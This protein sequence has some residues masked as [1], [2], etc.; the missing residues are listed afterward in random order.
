[1]IR[2]DCADDE[3]PVYAPKHISFDRCAYSTGSCQFD[4]IVASAA[5]AYYTPAQCVSSPLSR[6]HTTS[7]GSF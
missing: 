5:R 2:V 1:M 4:H 7:R 3:I 6:T